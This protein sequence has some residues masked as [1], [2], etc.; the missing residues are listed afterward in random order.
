M[1]TIPTRA[2]SLLLAAALLLGGASAATAQTSRLAPAD[3]P[4]T[5]DDMSYTGVSVLLAAAPD[6]VKGA[7]EKWADDTYDIDFD[8]KGSFPT[9]D[10]D[11][12]VAEDAMAPMVSR[13]AVRVYAKV[14]EEGG[15]SRMTLFSTDAAGAAFAPT[16]ASAAEYA[17]LRAFADEFLE[18]F[19]PEYYRERVDNVN[20]TIEDLREDIADFRDDIADNEQ[21]IEELR[22]ENVELR[23]NI[24]EAERNL[25]K[26]GV[27]LEQREDEMEEAVDEVMDGGR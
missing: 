10:K 17:G 14:V 9:R 12:L 8:Y 16:G 4:V 19:V 7:L 13:E 25:E 1:N 6:R 24:T 27:T 5:M 26:Q 21:E 3:A 22:E 20:A 18:D 11:F 23:N 15:G 2:S